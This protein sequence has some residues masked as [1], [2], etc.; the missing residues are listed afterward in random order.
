MIRLR[1][2]HCND[3]GSNAILADTGGLY[4]HAECVMPDGT[5]LGAHA[6][7]GVKALPPTYD[8]GKFDRQ[9]FVDLPC[10]PATATRFY[11][12]AEDHIGEPYD[13][14]AIA[15]FVAHFDLHEKKKVICSAL[16]T[17]C[18]RDCGWFSSPLTIPA[19][20]I[21]PRDLLLIISGRVPIKQ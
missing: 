14:L 12:A 16:M 21:S 19:H 9:L 11:K 15:G 7:I 18:L 10:E 20:Q 17:L 1:F 13:F 3:L 8:A 4:S 2:V 6:D 5:Y